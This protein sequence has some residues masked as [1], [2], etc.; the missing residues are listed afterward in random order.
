[1]T[2]PLPIADTLLSPI[3]LALRDC[4]CKQ[5]ERSQIGPVC[6]CYIVH[7][8]S[9]PTMDGCDCTCEPVDAEE[10]A[11]RGSASVRV[12]RL[13]PDLG[14]YGTG[15]SPCPTGWQVTLAM[16]VYRCIPLPE[17]EES[18]LP[19]AVQTA[20]ALELNSDLAA[21]LRVLGCCQELR[22][23]DMGVDFAGPLGPAAG[24]AGWEIQFSLAL[25]GPPG[26]C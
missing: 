6:S 7:H 13:A 14:P 23:R 18:V 10:R 16:V 15:P 24:C 5:L 4:L 21:M 19:A 8:Q 1:M 20:T 26:G 17:D 9:L 3:L 12:V 25:A 22:D 11:G 2:T